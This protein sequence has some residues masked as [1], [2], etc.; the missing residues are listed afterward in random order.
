MPAVAHRSG[1]PED[2]GSCGAAILAA[3]MA[4]RTLYCGA[5]KDE[6]LARIRRLRSDERAQWGRMDVAQMLAHCQV[7]FRVASG[8]L[9]LPRSLLGR[10]FGRIAL[11]QLVSDK[12]TKKNLPTGKEFRVVDKRVFD[13]ERDQLIMEIER[14]ASAGPAGL[15]K[16]AHPFFGPM[17]QVQWEI[18]M[19]K[20]LDH[21]LTQF[22]PTRA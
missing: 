9:K 18:L 21:H 5:D 4:H 13:R 17:T 11:K 10:L 2:M 7:P 20:H 3:S 19:W 16:D 22:T 14:F 12:P 6:M 1:A 15:T 8:E